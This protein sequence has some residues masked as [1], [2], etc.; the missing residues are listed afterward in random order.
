LTKPLKLLLIELFRPK[1][2]GILALLIADFT[3]T[4]DE[5]ALFCVPSRWR[6]F[7][8]TIPHPHTRPP[9][10]PM[11]RRLATLMQPIFCATNTVTSEKTHD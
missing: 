2:E 1:S 6:N 7:A 10:R 3:G 9:Y 8:I 4:A 11:S 5:A